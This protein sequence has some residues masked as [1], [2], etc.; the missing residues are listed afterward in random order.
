MEKNRPKTVL[1]R[2]I[3]ESKGDHVKKSHVKIHQIS[4]PGLQGKPLSY[5]V[6]D[7]DQ[8][9][10]MPNLSKTAVNNAGALGLRRNR[11]GSDGDIQP[12]RP[13]TR[14]TKQFVHLDRPDYVKKVAICGYGDTIFYD[15]NQVCEILCGDIDSLF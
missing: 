13:A 1:S 12:H 8:V 10:D 5:I 9:P 2:G 11:H 14:V 6:E 15:L 3:S 7:P 4:D